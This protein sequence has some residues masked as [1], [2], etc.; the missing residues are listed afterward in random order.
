MRREWPLSQRKLNCCRRI[1][2]NIIWIK[3]FCKKDTSSF[4]S[5]PYC[6]NKHLSFVGSTSSLSVSM[7]DRGQS[8]RHITLSYTTSLDSKQTTCKGKNGAS[9]RSH[10]E[11]LLVICGLSYDPLFGTRR[12]SYLAPSCIKDPL[13]TNK[14]SVVKLMFTNSNLFCV[15]SIQSPFCFETSSER[16]I[17]LAIFQ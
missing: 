14:A 2:L 8:P 17:S 5:Q 1:K 10:K 9:D 13:P 16:R 3:H 15:K 12:D 11:K 4:S 7:W 6:C